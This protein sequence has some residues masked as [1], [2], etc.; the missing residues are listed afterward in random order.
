MQ[1]SELATHQSPYDFR[2]ELLAPAGDWDCVSAAV[3]NGADAIY[4]GLD[5]GFNARARAA[6]F[7]LDTIPK[8]MKDLH[9]RGVRGYV[10][11]NTLAFS[12]ELPRVE[13]ILRRLADA[14]ADAVLVQDLGVARLAA[15]VCPELDLHASTQMTLTSAE[16]IEVAEQLGIRRVVLPREAS[17]DEIREIHS[18]TSMPLEAFVHGALCVAYSGQCLTSESLGGRSANRGQCAQAC[19]LPYE[20]VCDGSFIDL[21]DQKYLLSPQDLAA[22]ELLPELL[23]AG[24]CSFKIE[25]RLKSPE[26]V[27]NIT[28]HYRTALD[29]AIAGRRVE[30]SRRE[31]Q[32]MEQSFSR[33]FSPGWLQG[34]DHKMLV[35]ATSSS[36]RGVLLGEVTHVG[37]DRVGVLLE[38]EVRAGDGIV[39][40]GDRTEGSEQGGRVYHVIRNGV[41]CDE[42]VDQGVVELTFDRRAIDFDQLYPG[43][44]I[45]KTDDPR[46]T[47]ELRRTFET[48]DPVRR[49]PLNLEVQVITGQPI[50]LV[51]QTTTGSRCLAVSEH[52]PETARK[53]PISEDVLREQFGRLGGTIYQLNRL[54]CR[55]EGNPMVPLSVLGQ[56]RRIMI[57]QLD[58]GLPEINRKIADAPA[59]PALKAAI[60]TATHDSKTNRL[61]LRVMCRTL[62][63]LEQLLSHASSRLEH[64]AERMPGSSTEQPALEAIVDF[65]DIREYRHA[66]ERCSEAGVVLWLATPRIQKPG[67]MGLFRAMRKYQPEG[68]LVRNLSGLR[69]FRDEGIRVC[70]DF[71]L[72]ITNE[73]TADFLMGL[74]LERISPSYDL[75]RDQLLD[76]IR[77]VPV[78][79]LEIV[80]HQHMP[81]FHMEHCVFCSVLSP[82][83]NKTNCGRPCDVHQVE[84]RDRTG[85]DHP[86]VADV[87][88]RNTLFNAVPQS[89]AEITGELQ[90]L[91]ITQFRLELLREM[92][93]Q[94][95]EIVRLYERLLLG[96]V[97]SSIV[98]KTL[99]ASNRVGVTR[100]TLEADRNPLAIL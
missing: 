38:Y 60:Q 3:E 97:N 32:R 34:C 61:T 35:P 81:M 14:G 69:Y 84:L 2:P 68:V 47:Q 7:V 50:R 83:T 29:Q 37:T 44:R 16:C 5:D 77:V 4:L 86:L 82:G 91:G 33:G 73:L 20:L 93:T 92:E 1:N 28:Q 42:T 72:N 78:S 54:E 43:L 17:I 98:W 48:A 70:G 64:P 62:H 21:A 46:L 79:W 90:R 39:F 63:Q 56:L 12:N 36:K 30:F 45:W 52:I 8:L 18:K 27:A 49:V 100:G 23:D 66:V 26:Y 53:H 87:G 67:E 94:V 96:Q 75:N 85:V 25:G 51:G 89:S 9:S 80:I 22:W 24:V 15:A 71:S 10:T 74:G 13:E 88:C 11:L 65:Q 59:L 19:R 57:E 41:L 31:I 40:D 58:S 6:N 76:L 99:N 95:S 55:I